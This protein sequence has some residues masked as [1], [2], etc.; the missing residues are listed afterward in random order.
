M[1]I[2]IVAVSN[3]TLTNEASAKSARILAKSLFREIRANGHGVSFVIL[4][5]SE[6]IDLVTRS[7]REDT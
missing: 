5:A 4:L 3:T 2:V 6:L 1:L 7:G